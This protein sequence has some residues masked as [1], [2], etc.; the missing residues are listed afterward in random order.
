M[1]VLTLTGRLG[2]A[3]APSLSRAIRGA[4]AYPNQRIVIDFQRVDYISSAGIHALREGLALWKG[5]SVVVVTGLS[6]PVRLAL[7]LD[8]LLADLAV[9]GTREAGVARLQPS[10]GI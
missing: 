8:G 3:S 5:P 10:T 6:E 4:V 9:E 7:E 1:L 2:R